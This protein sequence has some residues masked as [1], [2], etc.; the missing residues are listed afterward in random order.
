[1]GEEGIIRIIFHLLRI[2]P[3]ESLQAPPSHFRE[4]ENDEFITSHNIHY[5]KSYIPVKGGGVLLFY[6]DDKYVM[7]FYLWFVYKMLTDLSM[8][9]HLC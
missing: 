9:P 2:H 8:N 1:M 5:V 4:G 3:S 6:I 7:T